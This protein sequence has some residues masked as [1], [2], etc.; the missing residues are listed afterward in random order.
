MSE[1]LE[2]L[3]HARRLKASVKELSV[4][5]L[6]DV[7]EKLGKIVAERE[8]EANAEAEANAERI[9]KIAELQKMI[10]SAGLSLVDLGS[11]TAKVKSTRAPRPAKYSIVVKGEI[12]TWTGQGRMPTVFKHQIENGRSIEDFLI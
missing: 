6:K 4:T 11:V 3:T 10:E 2:I 9:A 1:F 12:V 8:E 5:E 7:Y